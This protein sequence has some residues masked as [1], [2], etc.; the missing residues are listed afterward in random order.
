MNNQATYTKCIPPS[1]N[2]YSEEHGWGVTF[3]G[4][5]GINEMTSVKFN[6]IRRSIAA[7]TIIAELIPAAENLIAEG[8][9]P[10]DKKT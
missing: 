6:G 1:T 10:A 7:K 9:G 8:K 4:I 3:T 2:V 5:T